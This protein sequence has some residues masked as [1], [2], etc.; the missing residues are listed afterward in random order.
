MAETQSITVVPGVAELW[1]PAFPSADLVDQAA[2]MLPSQPA[3]FL[4]EGPSWRIDVSPGKVKVWT[5][6]EADADR[7]RNAELA[8]HAAMIDARVTFIEVDDEGMII[9]DVPEAVSCREITGWSAKSRARMVERLCDLDYAPLFGDPTRLLAMY[10]L[11]Y[12]GDWLPVAPNGKVCKRHLGQ[13]RKRYARAFGEALACVWK[14]EF[15]NRGAPHFHLL[16]RPPHA[17]VDGSPV[18][19][20]E[21]LRL[22]WADIVAH[23]DPEQRR[24]HE[25]AGCNVDYAEGLKATDPRRVAVYFTKHGSFAAKEYQHCVPEEWQEPGQGPGRFWGYWVLQPRIATVAVSPELGTQAGRVLRRYSHAQRVTRQIRRPRTP[26]G[27]PI[28]KYPEINGLAGALLLESRQGT[29]TY[30]PTRT[31]AVRAKN[32]RGWLSVNSGPAFA[33]EMGYYLRRYLEQRDTD[34]TQAELEK[35]GQWS[36]PLA[37]ARRL[38]PSIRRDALISK[39]SKY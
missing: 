34:T 9:E 6:D 10:T 21:W 26:R 16:G 20:R 15:Q 28:S 31:R 11:T 17:Y 12:P 18:N 7:R 35:C 8:A 33:C 36:T 32:G 24:R 22:T 14:L 1:K 29:T 13:L 37:R 23:P 2:A 25:L 19:F 27:Q 30:R 39:F 38:R 4:Q 5:Q 3:G